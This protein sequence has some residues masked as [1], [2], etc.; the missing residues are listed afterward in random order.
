MI[1]G[2]A[3]Q[4]FGVLNEEDRRRFAIGVF[5]SQVG[6]LLHQLQ[7]ANAIAL[8]AVLAFSAAAMLTPG[9][10]SGDH[11]AEML[12]LLIV[13]G[14][15]AQQTPIVGMQLDDRFAEVVDFVGPRQV[16]QTLHALRQIA[17]DRFGVF[18]FG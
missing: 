6:R 1:T 3:Q 12:D 11:K 8:H 17:G 9:K 15:S 2:I 10:F 5:L 16:L 4:R 7:R 14:R 18:L 13:L